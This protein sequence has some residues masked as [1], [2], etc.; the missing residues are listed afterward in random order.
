MTD[1]QTRKKWDKVA[2]NFD[3][4]AKRGSE[5]RWR[6]AK[7]QLFRRMGDGDILF[8][9]LGTGLDLSTFPSGKKVT[10]IDISPKM[11]EA[12]APRVAAY[13]GRLTAELMDVHEMSFP[14]GS[15]DQVFTS[16]TLC[17]VPNPVGALCAISRVLKRGGELCMFEHTG[18]RYYP[19]KGMMN[20]MTLLTEK[21]GPA[22]NRPTVDNVVAAGFELVEVN[23]VYLDIVKTIIARKP[24]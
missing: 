18:S 22:M 1:L 11:L 23:N 9:A 21:I 6:P 4:M 15:F 19:F 10:A 17:S 24:Q 7:E 13:E 8:M 20:L 14:D 3:L 2:P 16:C 5:V 12:A